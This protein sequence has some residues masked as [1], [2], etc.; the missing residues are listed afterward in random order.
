MGLG[1]GIWSV[2]LVRDGIIM[3]QVNTGDQT[4]KKLNSLDTLDQSVREMGM[5]HRI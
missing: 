3:M 1:R 5:S 4:R 2:S